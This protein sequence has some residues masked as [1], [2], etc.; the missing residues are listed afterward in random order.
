MK[1]KTKKPHHLNCPL[2]GSNKPQGSPALSSHGLSALHD[3]LLT[4]QANSKKK[5]LHSASGLVLRTKSSIKPSNGIFFPAGKS[6]FLCGHY[7]HPQQ[8]T[9][10]HSSPWLSK[11]QGTSADHF[12]HSLVA[13]VAELLYSFVLQMHGCPYPALPSQSPGC[14]RVCAH[15]TLTAIP[16]L[17]YPDHT[18]EKS[19]RKKKKENK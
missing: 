10:R 3:I 12:T 13:A 9:K 4:N 19:R 11:H 5:T 14:R 18:M 8:G 15:G 2:P 7:S 16:T 1:G 6:L 17:P